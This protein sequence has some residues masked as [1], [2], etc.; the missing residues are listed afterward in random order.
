MQR[1]LWHFSPTLNFHNNGGL[2][3]AVSIDDE[4]P[5]IITLNKADNIV[6]TWEEW[7]AHNIIVKTT[8]HKLE[9]PG[10]HTIK[11]WMLSSG[12]VL[13][14]IILDFGGIK[15]SYLGPPETKWK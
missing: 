1:F 5:Q 8:E 13:Q 9:K 7:V 10:K 2:Q 14:K 15:P 11:Y 12:I 6:K 3:F 4:K